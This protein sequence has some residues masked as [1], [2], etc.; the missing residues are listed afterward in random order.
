[1][2]LKE[3]YYNNTRKPIGLM[4]KCMVNNMNTGHAEVAELG[5]FSFERL[6]SE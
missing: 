6:E 4:G 5:N 1:M 3:K 2:G